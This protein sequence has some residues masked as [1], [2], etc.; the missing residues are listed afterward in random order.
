VH[1]ILVA[2]MFSAII[3]NAFPG[4]IYL[5]Q[6]LKFAAPVPGLCPKAPLFLQRHARLLTLPR[7][8]CANL[9]VRDHFVFM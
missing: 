8:E 7:R 9:C 4:A 6:T 2:S 5:S 1:G 3:G